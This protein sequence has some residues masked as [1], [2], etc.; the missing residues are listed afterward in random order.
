MTYA[1]D[2]VILCKKGK[3]EEALSR[4]REIMDK[5]KLTVNEKKTHICRVPEGEFDFLGYTFGRLYSATTGQARMGMRPS[6]KSIR[7]HG[8]KVH[9]MTALKTVWQETTELVAG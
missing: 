1:D 4:M 7:A 9:A 3:A 6:K 5:L 8:R 2:L